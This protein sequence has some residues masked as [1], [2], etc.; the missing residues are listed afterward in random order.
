MTDTEIQLVTSPLRLFPRA[1]EDS[2][3]FF[4]LLVGLTS[5][6]TICL[7]FNI[8]RSVLLFAFGLGAVMLL[9]QYSRVFTSEYRTIDKT[10]SMKDVTAVKYI[11]RNVLVAPVLV[12]VYYVD[13]AV[14][15]RTVQLSFT[16]VSKS[17]KEREKAKAIFEGHG[18]EV[19][20]F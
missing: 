10:I 16:W 14:K 13:G 4:A 15:N 20:G 9:I 17:A 6:F 5:L 11:E 3:P 7:V 19:R 8:F 12:I 1:Y 2:K 18:I